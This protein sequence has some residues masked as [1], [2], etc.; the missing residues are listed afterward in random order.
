MVWQ[1]DIVN[2]WPVENPI[3]KYHGWLLYKWKSR[4]IVRVREEN[5]SQKVMQ[6][7]DCETSTY[8]T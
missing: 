1:V 7:E 2:L 8:Y 6:E 5:A 3:H 4:Y